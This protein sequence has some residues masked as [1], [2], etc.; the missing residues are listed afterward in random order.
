MSLCHGMTI[1]L[2]YEGSYF[3][4]VLL[5]PVI[6]ELSRGLCIIDGSVYALAGGWGY[7]SLF[8]EHTLNRDNVFLSFLPPFFVGFVL[9]YPRPHLSLPTSFLLFNLF[10]GHPS[11]PKVQLCC[12]TTDLRKKFRA[13]SKSTEGSGTHT[14]TWLFLKRESKVH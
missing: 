14:Q 13:L 1:N 3:V 7:T 4:S 5:Y 8:T 10:V 12:Q 6:T 2:Y 9:K 11:P